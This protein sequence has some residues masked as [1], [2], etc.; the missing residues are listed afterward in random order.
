MGWKIFS[1]NWFRKKFCHID[2]YIY[3]YIYENQPK[4]SWATDYP[5]YWVSHFL[6]IALIAW[7]DEWLK[8]ILGGGGMAIY[9]KH[10]QVIIKYCSEKEIKKKKLV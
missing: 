1:P 8:G 3:I 9:E 6:S 4:S 10:L 2:I 7:C 5:I